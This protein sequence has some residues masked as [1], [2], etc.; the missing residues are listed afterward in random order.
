[1]SPDLANEPIGVASIWDDIL[2]DAD[3]QVIVNAG[4]G[5]TRGLGSSPL[6]MVIDCQYNYIGADEPVEQQQDRWPAGGGENA[7]AAVRVVGELLKA[8]HASGVPVIYTRNVQKRTVRFDSFA[9]KSTWDHSKTL[10]DSEGSR[11]VEEIAPHEGDFVLDKSYASAFYGTPLVNYLVGLGTD[12]L[13]LAGVSTG[14]CVRATAVDAVSR[15]FNVAVVAD[16]VAD[17]IVASHK[18][19]LL[20]MWMKYTDVMDSRSVIDYLEA[21]RTGEGGTP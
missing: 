16:A 10:D 13:I 3:R 12:T 21:G 8:A 19:A 5:K 17:R 6:L 1:M 7:W 11:I 20:D 9:G 2:T 14:G 15:G 4:Y 18:V